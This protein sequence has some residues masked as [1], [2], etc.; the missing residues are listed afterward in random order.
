VPISELNSRPA[1]VA[2]IKEFDRLGQAPF[3]SKYGYGKSLKYRLSYRGKLY[4]SKAIAGVAWGLQFHNDGKWRPDSYSGGAQSSVPTLERLGFKILEEAAPAPP[5]LRPG[6]IY[7]W[8]E[9]AAKFGF[10]PR[11]FSV[12]GGMLSCP[13]HGALLLMTSSDDGR[14]FSYGDEWDK[15]DLIYAGKGL[16]GH[17]QLNGVNRFVAENSRDLFLFEYAG[18]E[19]LRFH[20]RV[21]CV[22]HWES[23]DPDKEGRERRVL[24]FRLRPASGK[25]TQ[26]KPPSKADR[27]ADASHRDASSFQAR[28]FDPDREPSERRQ[29]APEDPEGRRVAQEQA[30]QKHQG[31][32]RTFGLWLERAGWTELQEIDGAIDL[33]AKRPGATGH[34]QVLFEIKSMRPKSERGAVRSG[35]AQLLE[36]RHFLGS[37]KDRLC[38]VTNRPIA[39]RRLRLLNSLGIGHAY[40]ERN[41]VHL[42][43]TAS[44]KAI[45]G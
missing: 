16:T 23:I 28:G 11:L 18:S 33:M 21:T 3:L 44:S 10:K 5:I 35:L 27:N 24:Q 7:S 32:L 25:R 42:S 31:I 4:D 43:A 14:S 12:G 1:V 15:G 17:Q 41:K 30:D 40:V 6:S 45:F 29:S 37:P 22:D 39:T 2:A 20:D 34:P 9:V 38:L 19:R 26:R 8:E 13:D 36:Y